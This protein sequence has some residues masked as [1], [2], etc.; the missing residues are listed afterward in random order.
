MSRPGSG[1]HTLFG[2]LGREVPTLSH[3]EGAYLVDTEGKRYLD[4]AS[5]VAV[6]CLGYSASSVVKA[7]QDQAHTL[8]YSY[9]GLFENQP[10]TSLAQKLAEWAPAG[11]GDIRVFLCSSGAEAAEAALKIAYQ[12][13]RDRG[14]PLRSGM[15]GRWGSYHGNTLGALSVGGREVWRDR[16]EP[17]LLDF[18]HIPPPYCYRC[19]WGKTYPECGL[20]CAEALE[21]VIVKQGP[22][23]VAAFITEP[24]VG[25]SISG[26][27]P[28]PEYYPRI[29]EICDDHGLLMIIDE[30]MSGV[31]RTGERWGI[32][33]WSVAPDIL[34]TAKGLAGG[35][36]PLAAALVSERVWRD[37]AEGSGRL[38][39][40]TTFSGHPVAAAAGL[41]TLE[42]I[43]RGRLI[44]AARRL[45]GMLLSGLQQGAESSPY[46]GEVRG[47][48]LF[49]GLEL[50]AGKDTQEPFPAELM[51]GKRV[52]REAL[53]QGLVTLAGVPAPSGKGPMDHLLLTPP[54]ILEEGQIQQ[55]T[56]LLLGAI[57]RVGR[58]VA[59]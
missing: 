2:E 7:M 41:A 23:R 38:Y 21:E 43:E 1:G 40:S 55:I 54:Y 47:R 26:L 35:Y 9:G 5:G 27:V 52:Q 59:G 42:D 49:V 3:G 30:V 32:D 12:Y 51:V 8:S 11:M 44:E 50:V 25:T 20:E 29:R 4:A 46:I 28:P 45:G 19:P 16:F 10:A 18:A 37:I 17:L 57:D 36:A 39:H 34:I 6:A 15:I 22:E 53:A 24:M 13:H 33:H 58:E 56:D 14:D 31:G 48:G